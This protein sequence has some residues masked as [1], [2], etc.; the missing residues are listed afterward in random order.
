MEIKTYNHTDLRSIEN[1]EDNKYLFEFIADVA[2]DN[3][4]IFDGDNHEVAR[5]LK[6]LGAFG[7]GDCP[8][9]ESCLFYI[10]FKSKKS[11]I[12]FIKKLSA[13]IRQKKSILEKA[14]AY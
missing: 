3:P 4:D 13:Y 7:K 12:E 14:Q 1:R 10:Y 2:G 6:S 9:E 5:K 11:G 8:D